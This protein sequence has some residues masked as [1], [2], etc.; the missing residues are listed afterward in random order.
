MKYLKKVLFG[1]ILTIILLGAP[2]IGR[3]GANL[4]DFSNLDPDG[5]FLWISVHHIIQ[6]VVIL[7]L[8]FISIKVFSLDF[9]LGL[10]NKEV[11][12]KYLKR[13]MFFFMIYTVGAFGSMILMGGFQPFQYPLT[14]L[15]ITGYL[16]FQLLLSGPSEELIFRAFAITIFAFLI[17][18]KRLNKHISYANLFAAII[19]G[20]A[21]VYIRFSPFEINYTVFQVVYA[22]VLGYFYGDCYEKSKSVIY[23][24][25]MHSFTNV[26]MIG[27]T[28][29]LS[30][31]L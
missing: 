4:F 11:G 3:L 29:I 31:I 18:D 6:A 1:I 7:I 10:G 30:F 28:V 2:I 14:G 20:L 12:I 21:H 27:L 17:T 16:G 22:T 8:I 26:V 19:F 13:F 24:M 9:N 23:P 15:N 25:I 5:S